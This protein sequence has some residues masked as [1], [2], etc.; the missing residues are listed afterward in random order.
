RSNGGVMS[1]TLAASQPAAMMESGPVAGMIAAGR[2]ARDLSLDRCIGFDMG[3]T[4]AKTTLITGGVPAIEDGYVIGGAARGHAM[5]LPVVDIVEVGAGGGSIA[6]IDA[7]RGLHVGPQSA[8]ADPRTARHG[9]GNN[10][11]VVTDANLLLGRI[12]PERFL[13]G[14]LRL[15]AALAEH[16]IAR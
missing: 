16:A 3:G 14:E 12:N 13:N 10:Q 9:K 6:W 15:D 5:Q 1:V 8:G 11:P 4:T 7:D 2:L